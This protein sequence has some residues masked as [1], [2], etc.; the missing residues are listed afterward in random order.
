MIKD[1]F[2][3]TNPNIRRSPEEYDIPKVH[4]AHMC[5]VDTKTGGDACRGDSGGALMYKTNNRH[6]AVGIVSGAFDEC[7]DPR[8]PGFYTIVRKF[9]TLLRKAAPKAQF[10]DY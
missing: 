7:G 8:T 2:M 5:C 6:F 10:C 1:F 4:D 9:R 3:R